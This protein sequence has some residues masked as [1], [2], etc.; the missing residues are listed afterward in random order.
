[1][2][3]LVSEFVTWMEALPPLWAYCIVFLIA[4]GENVVPPIPGDL[5]VVFG[6]Y[7]AGRGL[8]V[9]ALARTGI[10]LSAM[11]EGAEYAGISRV[12]YP[13]LA[14]RDVFIANAVV[15]GLGLVVSLYPAIKAAR[16]TPVRAMAYH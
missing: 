16:I 3:D 12:V 15:L 5:I 9:L 11:A 4:Y 7:L 13:A 10:D 1:M 8:R 2:A 6:G 14:G